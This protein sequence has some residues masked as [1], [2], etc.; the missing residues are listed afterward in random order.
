[1]TTP[2]TSPTDAE[3]RA[4]FKRL[5]LS[6]RDFQDAGSFVQRLRGVTDGGLDLDVVSRRA[7]QIALVVSY[8]RPFSSNRGVG[9]RKTL[10]RE[11]IER[12]GAEHKDMH[13]RLRA[14][15]DQEF[16]HSDGGP[17]DIQVSV[18]TRVDGT[19]LASHAKAVSSTK[20][21]LDAQDLAS[22][23]ALIENLLAMCMDQRDQIEKLLA[24]GARF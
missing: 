4:T 17:A 23:E 16:A 10:P 3:R 18:A 6:I 22:I 11:F 19:S 9:V 12:L 7:L 2:A 21:V 13:A 5:L 1:M 24:P 15:R 8:C 20:I 14:L